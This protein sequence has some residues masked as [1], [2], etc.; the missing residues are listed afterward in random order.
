MLDLDQ[1]NFT[2]DD[3][4][5]TEQGEYYLYEV[6]HGSFARTGSDSLLQQSFGNDLFRKETLY[7]ILGSDSGLFINYL[8]RRELP[9][10]SRYFFIEP[11]FLIDAIR[12]RP[13]APDEGV[14]EHVQLTTA[15]RLFPSIGPDLWQRY[16]FRNRVQLIRSLG[17]T[18]AYLETYANM[19]RDLKGFV[20]GQVWD[21]QARASMFVHRTVQ[22]FNLGDNLIPA[23]RMAGC[24]HGMTAVVTAGGPSLAGLLPWIKANRTRLALVAVSRTA[25]I[26]IREGL[27]PDI[28]VTLDPFES[29]YQVS[30]EML[31]LGERTLLVNGH[32]AYSAL[33]EGWQGPKCY[34]GAPYPWQEAKADGNFVQ[35]GPSVTND[36]LAITLE[37]GCTTVILAGVDLCYGPEGR[38]HTTGTAEGD[39]GPRLMKGDVFVTTNDGTLA[40]TAHEFL[41]AADNVNGF[42]ALARKKGQRVVNPSGQSV[43]LSHVEF[44]PLEQLDIPDPPLDAWSRLQAGLPRQDLD[45]Q[46]RH[47]QAVE[48]ELL[49]ATAE[50]RDIRNLAAEA[51]AANDRLHGKEGRTAD[52]RQGMRIEKIERKIERHKVFERFLKTFGIRLFFQTIRVDAGAEWT[53]L[54]RDKYAGDYYGAYTKTADLV[55]AILNFALKRI[56]LRAEELKPK[57]NLERL[58]DYWSSDEVKELDAA[59][60]LEKDGK[61]YFLEALTRSRFMHLRARPRAWQALRPDIAG[62]LP[63]DQATRLADLI[64]EQQRR[65]LEFAATRQEKLKQDL[66][67]DK[68]T[69]RALEYFI[70][71]NRDGLERLQRGLGIH[72]D[73]DQAVQYRH[74]VE[75]YLAELGDDPDSALA[76]YAAIDLPALREP[77]LKR[78]LYIQL[79]RQ[80][81][82]AA[83]AT[84]ERLVRV[85]PFYL[86]YYADLLRITDQVPLAIDLFTG[87]LQRCPFDLHTMMKLGVLYHQIGA[88]ES[89]EWVLSHVLSRQPNNRAAAQLLAELKPELAAEPTET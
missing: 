31:A 65:T 77:A 20:S 85:S 71:R 68:L 82:D 72:P 30:H 16:L 54:D 34:I 9:E 73:Q 43:R 56:R 23:A 14:P 12:E 2:S 22:L 40:E 33:V 32:H 83:L 84:L 62:Q 74:L 41:R 21:A 4:M 89:A 78:S 7:L 29:S 60:G 81:T 86:P 19:W 66:S 88:K 5:A 8:C 13:G 38:T 75:G 59:E 18:D 76:S 24:L 49:N 17:A 3:F 57:P 63:P 10:A 50:V 6:N 45:A 70:N 52:P 26:L 44:L 25:G 53:D 35:W 1:R 27:T 48:K 28:L 11:D 36:A 46:R 61:Q 80:D 15:A 47:C 37:F 69:G 42:A 51:L 87:Y 64:Q 55:L 79:G 58:L 67:L 39:I